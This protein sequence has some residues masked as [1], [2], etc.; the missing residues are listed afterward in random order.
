MYRA[1]VE[2]RHGDRWS[3]NSKTLDG[4]VAIAKA[5]RVEIVWIKRITP[6]AA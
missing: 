2:D 1:R 3:I 6:R 4:I 5:Q